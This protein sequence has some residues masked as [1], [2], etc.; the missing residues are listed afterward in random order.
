MDVDKINKLILALLKRL[1]QTVL[2]LLEGN[3]R[4]FKLLDLVPLLVDEAIF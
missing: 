2:C 1:R 4:V 3:H